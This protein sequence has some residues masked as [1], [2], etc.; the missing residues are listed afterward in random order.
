MKAVS[1]IL[2]ATL[3]AGSSHASTLGGG[4]PGRHAEGTGPIIDLV[5]VPATLITA[6]FRWLAPKPGTRIHRDAGW[7][8]VGFPLEDQGQGLY[9]EIGGKTQIGRVEIVFDD[10]ALQSI[11]LGGNR[12]YSRG[13]YEL[14]SFSNERKVLLVRM[15]AR[16]YSSRARMQVLLRRD[17]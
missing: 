15:Q 16:A 6:P 14:A 5:S 13:F 8:T 11:E 7:T 3:I 10:G 1:L 17:G 4:A 2:C 9:L 12:I